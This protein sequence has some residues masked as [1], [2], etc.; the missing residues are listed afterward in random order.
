MKLYRAL[1]K[2]V[3]MIVLI[4]WVFAAIWALLFGMTIS[5]TLGLFTIPFFLQYW[6]PKPFS[7]RVIALVMLL[8][9]N[10]TWY[11]GWVEYRRQTIQFNCIAYQVYYTI[12][13]DIPAWCP[14]EYK[15][16]IDTY[17]YLRLYK[18]SERIAI[19]IHH[20]LETIIWDLRGSNKYAYQRRKLVPS[21][22]EMQTV[23]LIREKRLE[24]EMSY[25]RIAKLLNSR[26]IL[27]KR[28]R[29]WYAETIKTVC[30]NTLYGTPI[31]QQKTISRSR[32]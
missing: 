9:P 10:I 13:S 28:G 1:P 25:H 21:D 3:I 19:A 24:E 23:E 4:I 26:R 18:H 15:A 14:K 22:P 6:L 32:K 7:K 2:L 29:R 16:P 12:R 31:S 27:S 8:V 5:G 30:E 11:T 17:K 20:Y